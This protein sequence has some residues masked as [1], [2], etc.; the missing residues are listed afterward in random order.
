MSV[1]A[2]PTPEIAHTV[3]RVKLVVVDGNEKSLTLS[4]H[5]SVLSHVTITRGR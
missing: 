2:P 4:Q 3:D 5:D 1:A